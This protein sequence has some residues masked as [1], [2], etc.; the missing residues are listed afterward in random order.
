MTSAATELGG[1]VSPWRSGIT[2]PVEMPHNEATD[3]QGGGVM[4]RLYAVSRRQHCSRLG[5][6]LGPSPVLS[7]HRSESRVQTCMR[8]RRGS[9]GETVEQAVEV[10]GVE[11]PVEWSGGV[12][13]PGFE[14][15]DLL[16][17]RILEAPHLGAAVQKMIMKKRLAAGVGSQPR[18]VTCSRITRRA[19]W[20]PSSAASRSRP[21]DRLD[22]DGPTTELRT[23]PPYS[24]NRRPHHRCLHGR[25]ERRDPSGQSAAHPP[26]ESGPD[27]NAISCQPDQYHGRPGWPK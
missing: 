17:Q 11:A 10:V 24:R 21:T 26:T 23:P 15:G 13:V 16:G 14:R 9:G 20:R 4:V 6:G 12:V 5:G 22:T 3:D 25:H 7:F 2:S 19:L 8:V 1:P 27:T 18:S